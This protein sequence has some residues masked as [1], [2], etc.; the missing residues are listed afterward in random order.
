MVMLNEGIIL[1]R[2]VT[3]DQREPREGGSVP[4]G[5]MEQ[6]AMKEGSVTRLHDDRLTPVASERY[7]DAFWI[8]ADLIINADMIQSAQEV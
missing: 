4:L 7:S 6:I 1:F 2:V 3:V 5:A 8:R